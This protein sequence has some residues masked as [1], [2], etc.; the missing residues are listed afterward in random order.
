MKESIEQKKKVSGNIV[1]S[2]DANSITMKNDNIRIVA[3]LCISSPLFAHL[4]IV[5]VLGRI[6]ISLSS[7]D[8]L[9]NI[10]QMF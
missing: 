2:V 3:C 4:P 8:N 7:S 10:F 9:K 1:S 5:R 6:T